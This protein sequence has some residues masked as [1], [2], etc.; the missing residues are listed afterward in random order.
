[1]EESLVE[2]LAAVE[3]LASSGMSTQWIGYLLAVVAASLVS[4]LL[5]WSLT[6]SIAEERPVTRSVIPLA[7]GGEVSQPSWNSVAI[8][9]DARYFAYV[10]QRGNTRQLCLRGTD[11]LFGR[12][13]EG[14]EGARM[15]FFSPD[16]QWLGFQAGGKLKKVSLGGGAPV[17]I[18]PT[19]EDPRG[20]SWSSD[21]T[22]VF[23]FT[24]GAGLSRVSSSGGVPEA[25]TTP[26]REQG[27]RTHRL[28]EVLPG[29]KAVLFTIGSNEIES[30]DDASIAVLSLD[31][32][33]RLRQCDSR[34]DTQ[35]GPHRFPV[36]SR[37]GVQP[38]LAGNR[39]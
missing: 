11:E 4:G 36:E 16:S 27:E 30:W 13:I 37:G 12:P 39:W 22:I 7:P 19:G 6:R 17:I 32:G 26:N 2:P 10:E 23:N 34:L 14:T 35:G 8:S 3:R 24:H 1:M 18:C 28:P 29:G 9:R 25:L 20:A 33:D 21:G 15:P 38:L 31:S 5:V